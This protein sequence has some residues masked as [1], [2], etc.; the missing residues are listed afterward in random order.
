M[1][2]PSSLGQVAA[3]A[4]DN[5]VLRKGTTMVT[6][7]L[8]WLLIIT[9]LAAA[10]ALFD[11]IARMRGR[12]SNSILAIAELLFALLMLLSL[13]FAFPAPLGTLLFAIVLEVIL[14]LILLIRGT[15]ARGASTVTIIALILNS[16]VVLIA[17]G[18][19]TIPGLT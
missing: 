13:F 14:L 12:R 15:G 10:L 7:T 1:D 2:L 18:W 4:G 17:L 8:S 6:V 19:L 5:E 16:I 3:T 11:G 9:I